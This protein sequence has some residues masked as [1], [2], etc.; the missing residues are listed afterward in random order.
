MG[1]CDFLICICGYSG[2][3]EPGVID[4]IIAGEFV[5]V[6]ITTTQALLLGLI[7]MTPPCVMVFLS[8]TLKANANRLVNI[9]LGI[10]YTGLVLITQ[11]GIIMDT[12]INYLFS[13]IVEVV[14]TALIVWYA[15]KWPKQEA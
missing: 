3:F 4:Q 14:L 12:S 8:L 15:W 1:S 2:F 10:F 5:A 13:G 11:F 7:T 9:T 6:G